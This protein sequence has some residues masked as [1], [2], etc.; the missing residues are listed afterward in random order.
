VEHPPDAAIK[1]IV[2][3]VQP[4]Q[5]I[6]FGPEAT[7]QGFQISDHDLLIVKENVSDEE[8]LTEQIATELKTIQAAVDVRVIDKNKFERLKNDPYLIFKDAINKSQIVYR[9]PSEIL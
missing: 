5:I 6:F 4:E 2:E 9:R 1:K 8:L 7:F 3:F